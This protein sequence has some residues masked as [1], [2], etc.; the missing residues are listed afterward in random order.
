M[1][2]VVGQHTGAVSVYVGSTQIGILS[3]LELKASKDRMTP[4]VKV[5]FPERTG[6]QDV[7]LTTEESVRKVSTLPWV[8]VERRS[9]DA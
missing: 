5:T 7:D 3:S 8:S 1:T 9:S 2:I 6:N 4:K